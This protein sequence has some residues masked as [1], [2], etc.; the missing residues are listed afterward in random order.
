MEENRMSL[1]IFL[2]ELAVVHRN[3]EENV[4]LCYNM[5]ENKLFSEDYYTGVQKEMEIPEYRDKPVEVQLVYE[6][7]FVE[8]IKKKS[9]ECIFLHGMY[10]LPGQE[11]GSIVF[12]KEY[13]AIH[14]N[15]RVLK[16]VNVVN[17]S[18]KNPFPKE[19]ISETLVC[20]THENKNKLWKWLLWIVVISVIIWRI[21]F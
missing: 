20:D 16:K 14:G 1:F 11:E 8:G 9:V 5:H 4:S 7:F 19:K 3:L 2:N 13:F 6:E 12:G 21:F 17:V 18:F 10:F 15:S